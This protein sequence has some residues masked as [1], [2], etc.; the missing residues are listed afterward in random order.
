M[1]TGSKIALG[2][3][4]VPL[5]LLLIAIAWFITG[6]PCAQ[7]DAKRFGRSFRAAISDADVSAWTE[8]V[9]SAPHA[10]PEYEVDI[11]RKDWPPSLT[12]LLPE[13]EWVSAT[14]YRNKSGLPVGIRVREGIVGIVIPVNG[15]I[16]NDSYF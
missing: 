13:R 6:E 9:L 16:P 8:K 1:K 3:S 12:K 15:T 10:G 14:L 11:P 5:L 4:G 7:K 2:V